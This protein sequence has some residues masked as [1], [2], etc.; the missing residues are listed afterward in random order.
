LFGQLHFPSLYNYH[1]FLFTV[2]IRDKKFIFM[3]SLFDKNSD[4]H[5]EVDNRM[6]L[7]LS[8]FLSYFFPVNTNDFISNGYL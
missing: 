8:W 4:L 3:D 2:D 1:W 7:F 5:Q 6:V